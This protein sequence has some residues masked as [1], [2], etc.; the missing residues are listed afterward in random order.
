MAGTVAGTRFGVAKKAK[1]ISVK[2]LG[3]DGLGDWTRAIQ[4]IEWAVKD[5]AAKGILH[6]SVINMS[7]GG[8]KS[9]AINNA[10][11]AAFDKGI[12]VVVA[13]G[14]NQ[15]NAA[16]YSPASEPSAITVGSA[17]KDDTQ[18]LYSNYGPLVDV[19]GPGENILSAGV[20]SDT[21]EFTFFGNTP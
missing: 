17:N 13:A 11:K 8:G 10:V 5:A 14:N 3:D 9:Q 21:A 2:V 1:V 7:L 6:K 20:A 18:G 4:G 16:D 15:G 12:L 19:F